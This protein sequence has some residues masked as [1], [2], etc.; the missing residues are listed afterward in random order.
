MHQSYK[1]FDLLNHLLKQD[2]MLLS[3][4]L[5]I[6]IHLIELKVFFNRLGTLF[7]EVSQDAPEAVFDLYDGVLLHSGEMHSD[8]IELRG[9]FRLGWDWGYAEAYDI[10]L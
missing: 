1:L 10:M 9:V 2:L 8:H 6:L 4:L 7:N 3:K 5:I